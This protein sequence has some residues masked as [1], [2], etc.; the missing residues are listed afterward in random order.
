MEWHSQVR[1]HSGWY[2]RRVGWQTYLHDY[3]IRDLRFDVIFPEWR[4]DLNLLKPQDLL[5]NLLFLNAFKQKPYL[6]N[7][8]MSPER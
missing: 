5:F 4:A 8:H 1:D 6:R 3:Y 2:P 7:P